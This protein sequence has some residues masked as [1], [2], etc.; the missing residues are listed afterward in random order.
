MP[1]AFPLGYFANRLELH[2]T[3]FFLSGFPH[4]YALFF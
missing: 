1:R 4:D 3:N 2:N